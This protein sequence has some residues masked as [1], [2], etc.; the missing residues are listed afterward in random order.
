MAWFFLR[1]P[2]PG[3]ADPQHQRNS[4]VC[5]S[6]VAGLGSA[7]WRSPAPRR[8][9]FGVEEHIRKKNKPVDE[10]AGF[11]MLD[12][13][14]FISSK[15]HFHFLESLSGIA[16]LRGSQLAAPVMSWDRCGSEHRVTRC[17]PRL[18]TSPPVELIPMALR[19]CDISIG[20]VIM[21]SSKNER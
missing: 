9:P 12:G 16:S 2:N 1:D 14:E 15:F 10:I 11:M 18:I 8:N 20:M 13:L 17:R 4:G 3:A 5:S 7:S 6:Q 19:R 21:T